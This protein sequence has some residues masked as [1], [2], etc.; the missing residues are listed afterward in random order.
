VDLEIESNARLDLLV[1]ELGQQVRILH[2]GPGQAKRH[3]LTLE[4]ARSYRGADAT[5]GALCSLIEGLSAPAQR[6][7]NRS[8]KA[9][10]IGR[11]LR[12][13]ERSSRITIQPET[14]RRV[15]GLGATLAVTYYPC[16]YD[17]VQT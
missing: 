5:I 9:F 14:L 16:E 7:W 6:L 12:P 3:L 8:Q 4:T 13:S 10:D 15:V 17:D 2:R 1:A 11:E